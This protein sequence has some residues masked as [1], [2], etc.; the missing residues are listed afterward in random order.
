[1]YIELRP[2]NESDI[3]EEQEGGL[4]KERCHANYFSDMI[5]AHFS[6]ISR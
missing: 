2:I 5:I 1:M 4:F 6:K 3:S